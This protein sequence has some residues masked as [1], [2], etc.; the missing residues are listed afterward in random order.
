[1]VPDQKLKNGSNGKR[2]ILAVQG[3][4][5]YFLCQNQFVKAVDGASL[6]LDRAEILAL[7]GETGSGKTVTAHSI[8]GLIDSAPGIVGGKIMFDDRNLLE[9]LDKFCRIENH[10]DAQTI[11]KDLRGWKKI[12][13]RRLSPVRGRRVT[14]I[15]QEPVSSLDPY[16][17]VG[18]QLTETILFAH[19]EKERSE[20]VDSALGWLNELYLQ[21]PDSYYHKYAWQMSGGEC[22]RVMIAMALAPHPELL[23][24]DEP[25]TSLDVSTEVEIRGLLLELQAKYKLSILFISHD[26]DLVSG[27]ANKMAVMFKGSVMELFP[28]ELLSRENHQ[29]IHPYTE[30]LF[31]HDKDGRKPQEGEAMFFAQRGEQTQRNWSRGCKYLQF[32][33]YLSELAKDISN[34]CRNHHPPLVQAEEGHWI[35]CWRCA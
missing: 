3:L 16:Y 6:W 24:A 10:G 15:F 20:A 14:M 8:L 33:P 22:Q 26:I 25:T 11:E 1:M 29:I 30:R 13:Q 23:I 28:A 12:Y 9:D 17:T 7:V 4:K 35:S 27:F 18:E 5:T 21:P 34:H 19:P 32:C 31:F 2:S